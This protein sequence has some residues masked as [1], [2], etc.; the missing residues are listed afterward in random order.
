M[1]SERRAIALAI[2]VALAALGCGPSQPANVL[3][4]SIDTLRADR[5]GCYGYERPTSPA[6][7][8]L[9]QG[10][11]LFENVVA[12]SPWTVPSH[13]TLFTGRF[14]HAHGVVTERDRLADD[15]P[16][17]AELLR[18]RGMRTAA[19]VQTTWLSQA[20]GFARGFDSFQ[21]IP[22]HAEGGVLVSRGGEAFLRAFSNRPFFL[23][24]HYYD[25]HSEY[26]PR[27]RYEEMFASGYDGPVDGS[28]MQLQE[29]RERYL[30][31]SPRDL[32]H[33]SSL[34][35]AEIRQLDDALAKLFALLDELGVRDETLVVVT[36]DHG[37]EFLEH[38]NV[39]HGRTMY[40]EVL[41]VPLIL[42]GPGVPR[43]QR[44]AS[45]ASLADV[46]PTVL[47]R[48]GVPAPDAIDG[49]D[50]LGP[51]TSMP[52][53]RRVVAA[54]DHNNTEPDSLRMI[55]DRRHKLIVDRVHDETRLFDL[56]RDPGEH[57]DVAAQEPE[58]VAELR[59][60]LDTHVEHRRQAPERS[61]LTPEETERLRSLGYLQP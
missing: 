35:D 6:L 46:L 43:G 17:L 3:L 61:A 2:G 31:L 53:E 52:A 19:V 48:L 26:R 33:L 16:V 34:Y 60:E 15:I 51:P 27:P 37:E 23:F 7:D 21:Q 42:N 4:I 41:D 28:A 20:Q 49:L 56:E 36:S 11:T 5:L 55:Q 13:A 44:V 47:A 24:L 30:V 9:A 50:L 14:P 57:H 29:I 59:R 40:R 1:S 10:G 54:A 8:A 45:L 32:E 39:L 12:S 38:G 58:R 22:D 18:T 25:V